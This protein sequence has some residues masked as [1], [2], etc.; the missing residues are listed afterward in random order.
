MKTRTK[1]LPLSKFFPSDSDLQAVHFLFDEQS[2]LCTGWSEAN[3]SRNVTILIPKAILQKVHDGTSLFTYWHTMYV[4]P[5]TKA[6]TYGP[7][8]IDVDSE[9]GCE[10]IYW[11]DYAR[12]SCCICRSLRYRNDIRKWQLVNEDY[13]IEMIPETL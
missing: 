4:C 1:K 9:T 7:C 12:C 3:L 13:P 10:W 6:V 8:G 11:K 2:T 5:T